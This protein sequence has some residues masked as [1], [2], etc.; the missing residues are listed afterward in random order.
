MY[1]QV[2]A[3]IA[4]INPITG[5]LNIGLVYTKNMKSGFRK[6]GDWSL[7]WVV[8]V[9]LILLPV[10]YY[11]QFVVAKPVQVKA[12][13]NDAGVYDKVASSLIDQTVSQIK[14]NPQSNEIPLNDPRIAEIFKKS[15]SPEDT[16]KYTETTIDSIYILLEGKGSQLAGVIDYSANKNKIIDELGAYTTE[17]LNSLPVCTYAQMREVANYNTFNA[18]CRPIGTTTSQL[19]EQLKTEL[20][21]SNTPL[22]KDSLVIK[23]TAVGKIFGEKG[24]KYTTYYSFAKKGFWIN[25]TLLIVFLTV[26][27]YVHRRRKH[28]AIYSVMIK[29]AVSLI[30]LAS[31]SLLFF[32]KNPSNVFL[33]QN[34]FGRDVVLPVSYGF[35]SRFAYIEYT[36]AVIY[37]AG[38]L[39][40]WLLFR[41]LKN[42]V[43][44]P[45]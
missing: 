42:G 16:K 23:D 38:A 43:S 2:A 30:V 34:E 39:V 24:N 35:V 22:S 41:R 7:G 28:Q 11:F 36:L 40:A 5:P 12:I 6:I 14:S 8:S 27:L 37:L 17:R 1:I 10:T 19:V 20:R 45:K 21:T 29:S 26:F 32:S 33:R 25:L 15:V 31:L 3:D 9:L 18:P 4:A 13:L 44:Q